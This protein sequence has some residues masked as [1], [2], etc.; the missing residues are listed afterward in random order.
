LKEITPSDALKHPNW[1]MGNKITI[2]SATLMN[3]GLELIEARWLFNCSPEQ[4]DVV[5]HPQSIIH[6]FVEFRDGSIKAQLSE[7][8]MRLPIRYAL[9]YPER[10]ESDIAGIDFKDIAELTF[11]RPDVENFRNLALAL[12]ALRG[13]GNLPCI[14]NASNE[15]AVEAFLEGRIGFLAI[16]EVVEHCLGKIVFTKDPSFPDYVETDRE[17]RRVARQ[18]IEDWEN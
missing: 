18:L 14:L 17:T 12:E 16:S 2:D 6:S 8:D 4:L 11:G 10:I 9:G 3:K 13:G 7:P 1:D 5:I 15:I